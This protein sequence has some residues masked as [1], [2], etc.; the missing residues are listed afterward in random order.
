[1][2]GSPHAQTQKRDR[3]LRH[4]PGERP[5]TNSDSSEI[6]KGRDDRNSEKST[7]KLANSVEISSCLPHPP[8]H[9][10]GINVCHD[11]NADDDGYAW[12]KPQTVVE[13]NASLQGRL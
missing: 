7:S 4:G 6:L 12:T 11:S 2:R 5:R 3:I 9:S 1:M 13:L 8:I 10:D